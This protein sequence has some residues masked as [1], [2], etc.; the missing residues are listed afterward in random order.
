MCASPDTIREIMLAALELDM[1]GSGEYV[2]FSV[3]L[4]SSRNDS[5]KPWFRKADPEA[6]NVL[7]QKAYEALLTVVARTPETED[8]ENF[9]QEVKKL[10]LEKFNFSFGNEEVRRG[11]WAPQSVPLPAAFG[12]GLN[13][14]RTTSHLESA[15]SPLRI[16]VAVDD[17][18]TDEA[19]PFDYA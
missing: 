4:F 2:F 12:E 9:S 15:A 10:A 6:K 16:Q 14:T 19:G 7:A 17:P 11:V 13:G 3:E 5:R 8:F 18:T 1:V